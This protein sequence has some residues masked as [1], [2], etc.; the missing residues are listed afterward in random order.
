MAVVTADAEDRDDVGVVQ[1]RRGAGLSL[2]TQ[3]LIGVGQRRVRQDLE[4]NPPAQRLLL[5]L[6][7]DAHAAAA[8]FA[9]DAVVAQTLQPR[10]CVNGHAAGG[11][12]WT[13]GAEVF[14]ADQHGEDVA[15][16]VGDL[17]VAAAILLERRPLAAALTPRKSSASASTG[18]RSLLLSDDVCM[19][20]SVPRE[21]DVTP[22]WGHQ[23]SFMPGIE[24][25]TSLSRFKARMYRLLAALLVRPS[26][27]AVSS[28]PSNSK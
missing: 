9:E 1:P 18:F 24:V 8:D 20:G 23:P 5:G 21:G 15:D 17:G 4:G 7:D 13:V 26:T 14:H 6:V 19:C 27:S 22:I 12:V 11:V 2:K 16:L 10:C 28:L 3:D 25:R